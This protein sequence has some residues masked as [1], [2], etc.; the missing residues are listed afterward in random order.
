[1]GIP[2]TWRCK[3]CTFKGMDYLVNRDQRLPRSEF[4]PKF[5]CY[6]NLSNRRFTKNFFRQI[7]VFTENLF[8]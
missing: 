5:W 2:V 1:M 4:E 8:H 7:S 3:I 6:E